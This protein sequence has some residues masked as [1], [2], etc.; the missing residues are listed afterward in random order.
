MD[1]CPAPGRWR[2]TDGLRSAICS[3]SRPG[4]ASSPPS[5]GQ[6]PM[7][8]LIERIR[9]RAAVVGVIGQ[10]YVGLPLALVFE[11]AGFAVRG[12]DVDPRKIEALGRGESYIEHIGSERVTRAVERGRFTATTD[13]DVLRSATPS[14]PACRRR[15][16]HTA[17]PTCRSST[18]RPGRSPAGS[19]GATRRARV[20]D[21]PGHHRRG[22]A[23]DSRGLGPRLPGHFL[24]AFS[25][26]REDPGNARFS[27]RT[28]PRWWAG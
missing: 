12:L 9:S 10:G 15:S 24:L 8:P 25:P 2:S 1:A 28:I 19:A 16:G 14:H 21:L 6:L 26:E 27:T 3:R 7:K 11:E 5:S 4:G 22:G 17:S 23:A 20:D 18:R 13:F